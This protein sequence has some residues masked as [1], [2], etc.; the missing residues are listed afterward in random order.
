MHRAV[1]GVGA[2]ALAL[3]VTVLTSPVEHPGD[4]VSR[5]APARA[6][7]VTLASSTKTVATLQPRRTSKACSKGLVALTFD[8]GPSRTV[9]PGLVRSLLRLQVPATFFLV[10][11]RIKS[12]P[13]AGR[14]VQ[15]SGFGIGNHTWSHPQLTRLSDAAVKGQLRRTRGAMKRHGIT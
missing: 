5:D 3:L 2:G 12:A 14:L 15:R 13:A 1:L 6:D 9:T 11:S 10:G 7:V 4:D 8:D